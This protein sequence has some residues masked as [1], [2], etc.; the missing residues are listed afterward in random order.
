MTI[1]MHAA[2]ATIAVAGVPTALDIKSGSIT[3]DEGWAPYAQ[4][5]LTVAMPSQAV[6]DAIDPR[7]TPRPRVVVVATRDVPALGIHQ[8]RTFDLALTDRRLSHREATIDIALASDE[9]LLQSGGLVATAPN[10]SALARQTS[11]RAIVNSN[12]LATIGAALE[13]G[14]IDADFTT[15]TS[16]TNMV[17]NP[18]AEVDVANWLAQSSTLARTTAQHQSGVAAF[19]ITGTGSGISVFAC[20]NTTGYPATPGVTYTFSVYMRT[21]AAARLFA[22]R[23]IFR[24]ATGVSIQDTQQAPVALNTGGWTR[25]AWT[26]VAPA[27]A[28]MI[29]PLITTATSAN[30]EVFFADSA[31]L[32]AGNGLETD[33]VAPLAYFDGSTLHTDL[34]NYQWSGIAH[35][36]TSS[37]TPV[38]Q[39]DPQTLS[40]APG[41]SAYDFIQP[42]LE[43]AGLRLFC[44]EHRVWRLVDSSYSVEGLVTVATG[45]NVYDASDTIS[46]SATSDDGVPLWF[47]AVVL[48]Y[49][50]NDT[51]NIEQVRY[52]IAGPLNA[53]QVYTRE[54]ARPYPGPGAASY[55]LSRVNGRG[56]MLDLTA[57]IDYLATPGMEVSAS[58]P[59]TLA[60]TGYTSSVT[61]DFDDDT[62]KVGSRGLTDTPANSWYFTSGSWASQSSTWATATT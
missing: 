58:L 50:W 31:M 49:V 18:S 1:S 39:R 42:V 29:A 3:L 52:D 54:I 20:P 26:A 47:D 56:R 35:A 45:Y 4:S 9:A 53:S 30:G 41:E 13:P 32:T 22:A 38:F 59:G 60:Q 15:L 43:Q 19:Q 62:M 40:W 2:S 27:L 8:T 6:F 14:T 17:V 23:L 51:E 10:T 5:S 44:D 12:V 25:L 46:R 11:V 48:K 37:R 61:W 57:A 7:V 55:I 16:L 28:V 21:A 24:N 34:Y 36:S 33:G